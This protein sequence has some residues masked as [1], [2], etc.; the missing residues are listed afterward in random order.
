MAISCVP[1]CACLYSVY[2]RAFRNLRQ[3]QPDAKE[4]A[5]MLLEAWRAFEAAIFSSDTRQVLLCK[6]FATAEITCL[7]SGQRVT[8]IRKEGEG[9]FSHQPTTL[10][11]CVHGP[12]SIA[13]SFKCH[14]LS[15][16]VSCRSCAFDSC[17]ETTGNSLLGGFMSFRARL[18]DKQHV[19]MCN[20]QAITLLCIRLSLRF[21]GSN[22][23]S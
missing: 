9:D 14:G 2:E 10:I 17:S 7:V 11:I 18:Q 6:V 23:S 5:V 1:A 19:C 21:V 20:Q 16:M 8:C 15:H 4:E 22:P 3:E 12:L 13:T